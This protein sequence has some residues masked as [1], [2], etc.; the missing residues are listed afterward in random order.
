M[1]AFGGTKVYKVST[2]GVATDITG[3]ASI[4]SGSRWSIVQAPSGTAETGGPVYMSNGLDAPLYWTGSGNVAAW[5]GN[6]GTFTATINT[7]STVTG[8][9]A[10]VFANLA[11]GMT[12]TGTNI[13]SSTTIQSIQFGTTTTPASITLSN[14][15]TGSATETLT[16]SPSPF[17]GTSPAV[18]NGAFSVFFGNRIWMTSVPG[19]P[20]AVY[21]SDLV[22]AGAAGGVGDPTQWPLSNVVR[23]DSS[24]GFGITGISS[25]GPY[26]LVFKEF[27][28]WVITDINTGANR[29]LSHGIGC[30]AH[31]TIVPT[32]DGT[33]FLSSDQGVFVTTNGTELEEISYKVRPT[34]LGIN[35]ALRANACG[36]FYQNHY[37]LTFPAGSSTSNNRTLDYD[38]QLKAWFL[39]DLAPN[40]WCIFE[41]TLTQGKLYGA[42]PGT[43][44][45]IRLCFD[46]STYQDAGSNYTGAN[47]YSAY[48]YANWERF[49]YYV[50]RHR[51]PVPMVKKRVRQVYFSGS[52]V[53]TPVIFKDFSA[54]GVQQPATPGAGVPTSPEQP[55]TFGVV[56]PTSDARIYAAGAAEEWSVGWGDTG[57]NNP[58]EVDAYA[59]MIQFR[60]S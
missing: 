27:K 37:Y 20:S 10:S 25:V 16:A 51:V 8:I 23:F 42:I 58:F 7:T 57:S 17:Y 29:A 21:F 30:V 26:L 54:T 31:R 53:I 28:T 44:N 22:S 4:T 24:D 2:A 6:S 49:S 38:L 56:A 18:P 33:F 1:I 50:F 36:A 45:G 11:V 19:D 60:K 48:Y 59:Y 47:G 55:V 13:P 43:S 46:P 35:H 12:I 15:A 34:I 40:Q 14:A 41:P 39:H 3:S 5:T 32:A 9:P 52:G